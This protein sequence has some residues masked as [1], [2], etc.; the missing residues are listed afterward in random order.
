MGADA[1]KPLI[2]RIDLDE[3]EE[4]LRERHRPAGGPAPAVGPAQAEGH[5]AA[6]DR[7][8]LQPARR[9]TAGGSTTRGP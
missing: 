8:R 6:E 1:I 3:E 5:Q 2:D 4:K 7:H 9:R